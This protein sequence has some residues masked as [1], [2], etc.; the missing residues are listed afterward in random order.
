MTVTQEDM[1]DVSVVLSGS[2]SKRWRA[3]IGSELESLLEKRPGMYKN[4]LK[5]RTL[6]IG[7]W[8]SQLR[9]H[10]TD[11]ERHSKHIL[12]QK[13]WS[14]APAKILC[15]C[16]YVYNCSSSPWFNGGKE[17][18]HSSNRF[19]DCLPYWKNITNGESLHKSS[20]G[21]YIGIRKGK[22]LKILKAIHG[23]KKAPKM[24]NK[25]WEF[26][27][28]STGFQRL[29]SNDCVYFW[30]GFDGTALCMIT[31]VDGILLISTCL[32]T[33]SPVKRD[34]M[35]LF[36]M[37]DHGEVN[38][39]L[40]VDFKRVGGG[41]ELSQRNYTR[42]ILAKF[43]ILDCRTATTPTAPLHDFRDAKT[44]PTFVID[45]GCV[46]LSCDVKS[47]DTARTGA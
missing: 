3:I 43:K 44:L 7:E 22:V 23:F 42:D 33:F 8:Y 29:R 13:G 6:S 36:K 18:L 11:F 14:S 17:V 16:H 4:S 5:A 40:G 34:L 38:V 46:V 47:R 24:W 21:F 9:A 27:A 37:K 12:C 39:F 19:E 41:L 32:G 35:S 26:E 1:N 31:Y 2:D 15:A 45:E 30:K 20:R 25:K 28:K 10:L